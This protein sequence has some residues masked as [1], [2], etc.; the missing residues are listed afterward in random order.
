[1]KVNFVA[2]KYYYYV[3]S[4]FFVSYRI[5]HL[6]NNTVSRSDQIGAAKEK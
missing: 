6:S 4:H 1:M 2:Y 3:D 5:F